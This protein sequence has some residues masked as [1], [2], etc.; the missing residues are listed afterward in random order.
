MKREA[1]TD[2]AIHDGSP[3]PHR[4]L[5]MS[6]PARSLA[7][8]A[9]ALL[10]A[11]AAL[12]PGAALASTASTQLATKVRSSSATLNGHLDPEA[13]PGIVNC[14]FEWGETLAYGSEVACAEGNAFTSPADL[15]AHL[16]GLIAGKEYHFR[17][18]AQTTSSGTILGADQGFITYHGA[19]AVFGPDGTA[20]SQY[21]E[22][23]AGGDH[24]GIGI[25]Q[26]RR[27]L[28]VAGRAEHSGVRGVY[29]NEI[30]VPP[31]F[32]VLSGFNPLS[33]PYLFAEAFAVDGTGQSTAGNVYEST[34][35]VPSIRGFAPTGAELP[36]FPVA[37]ELS[38]GSMAVDSQGMLWLATRLTPGSSPD[39]IEIDPGTATIIKGV[40]APFPNPV[41]Q[42]AFDSE[43][44][45]YLS[46]PNQLWSFTKDSEYQSGSMI[47]QDPAPGFGASLT[48]DPSTDRAFVV[49]G[50]SGQSKISEYELSG[51]LVDEFATGF[52][53][54]KFLGIA[55]D[56]TNHY[57][58]VLDDT[59][60]Q[61]RVFAGGPPPPPRVALS[62]PTAV[63]ND[64]ATV[65]AS[66]NPKGSTLT[67]CHLQYVT[68]RAFQI[69]GFSDLSSGG[70]V[71]CDPSFDQIPTDESPHAVSIVLNGLT[72]NTTYR[73]LLTAA[74]L[75]GTVSRQASIRTTGPAEVETVGAPERT[76]TTAWLNGR[77]DPQ[78]QPT[79]YH[80]EYV[81]V[82][83]YEASGFATATAT[84]PTQIDT[85]ELQLIAFDAA[86]G[87]FRVSFGAQTTPD[88]SFDESAAKLAQALEA[89]PS[90]GSGNVQVSGEPG[91]YQVTFVG[92]LAGTDVP[93]LDVGDGAT[94]PKNN[95]GLPTN[96]KVTT[97]RQGG[98]LSHTVLVA[99]K[100]TGLAPGTTYHYRI[101]ADNGNVAG[102]ALGNDVTFTTRASDAPL[103][104]GRFSGPPGSD[105]AYEQVSLGESGGNPILVGGT[106]GLSDDGDRAIY[107]VSG[108]TPLSNAGNFWGLYFAQ[109]PPGEHPESGW[110]TEL[111]TPVRDQLTGLT[112]LT[113]LSD[114]S[115]STVLAFNG[116]Q[117]DGN[118]KGTIWRLG[119][120]RTPTPLA[121]FPMGSAAAL[122]LDPSQPALL[123]SDDARTVIGGFE[124]N[125]V[126]DPAYPT[127][128]SLPNL[129]DISASPPHLLSLLP[130]GEPA[131]CGVKV[132]HGGGD[133]EAFAERA[134]AHSLSADGKFL[135][136]NSRANNCTGP[137]GLYA[138]DLEAE[139]SKLIS[140]P[141]IS[142]PQCSAGFIKST[143]GAAFFWTQTRLDP[144]DRNPAACSSG[145]GNGPDGDVY[146][147]DT[148][149]QTLECVTCVLSGFDVDVVVTQEPNLE[150]R[151]SDDGSRVYFESAKPLLPGAATRGIYRVDVATSALA[152][153]G[154]G[155]AIGSLGE[156]ADLT[157]D[158]AVLTFRSASPLLN[159]QGG[160]V[161]GG[162][163]QSYRYDDR[164]RSLVCISCPEPG[165][166]PRATFP[167]STNRGARN[168][169]VITDQGDVAFTT[170]TPLL[171]AD[172]N[173]P[174]PGKD[175]LAGT[176]V[177]EWRDG[178]LLLVTDGLTQWTA[179]SNGA[180]APE[181][182][183]IS[184]SGRDLFFSAPAQYTED[185][186]DAYARLYD[187]RI[188][189][190]IAFPPKP[191][192]CPLEVCQG[193]P[194]GTPE[195]APPGTST[196]RGPGNPPAITPKRCKRRGRHHRRC[197]K[198]GHHRAGHR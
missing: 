136:F 150:I 140:G 117:L 54:A 39:L 198:R 182:A 53:T 115:L 10:L 161:N 24:G 177:Y 178:R 169:T 163:T 173:T 52:P 146:R 103:S 43:D 51:E 50:S 179:F 144:A 125:G 164:H 145:T 40:V 151:V 185:A 79:S 37:T 126:V 12:V 61:V 49:T 157:P 133:Y 171:P 141:P 127:A 132:R 67:A 148:S 122:N 45:L 120:G 82:A 26:S 111:I 183:G 181:V 92:S 46:G 152:Y 190:G 15:S 142:G 105:R 58:Y 93:Q 85:N 110:Q 60:K 20:A 193:T 31:A 28:F 154:S 196:F 98:D 19:V 21:P 62:P 9:L 135:Y 114:P 108:G 109:R 64:T 156:P 167:G 118:T 66:V 11:S 44:N 29:G 128:A 176:D 35:S 86:S 71:S 89:L 175:P 2:R 59:T 137:T 94:P 18:V 112:W 6:T 155:F 166:T 36:G 34:Y 121:Q 95:V 162:A 57:I 99:R 123:A 134:Q 33:V 138:R 149:D 48:I 55:V 42:I 100:L 23:T 194:N 27:R 7:L 13:D 41:N 172:Q 153:V 25:D 68:E 73:Y 78:G 188:G 165:T 119:P 197:G 47:A 8:A 63:G 87:Q 106:L 191:K 1:Q 186:P 102:A 76:A 96:F 143:P 97:Q 184:P 4:R 131:S 174:G 84:S 160:K 170:P 74:N 113:P 90:I 14:K 56:A 17:L 30:A 75:E 88:L 83:A 5:G 81:T 130:G 139:E 69:A 38:V 180:G 65:H 104:H 72:P 168:I 107:R 195:E 116:D 124:D 91:A 187:A 32:P 129:Y 192:P 101:V 147:Y 77:V 70:T 159:P 80:F 158:G 16:T 189:G 3:A 22:L